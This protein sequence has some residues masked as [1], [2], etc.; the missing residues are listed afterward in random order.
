MTKSKRVAP[1]H[2]FGAW[3]FVLVILHIFPFPHPT[4]PIKSRLPD[5]HW[6][7]LR[8]YDPPLTFFAPIYS[9][10][11]GVVRQPV[12]FFIAYELLLAAVATLAAF[13]YPHWFIGRD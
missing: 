13:K 4:R 12:P 6:E 1:M 9:A 5:S 3:I 2:R 11:L 7:S 8:I 10:V